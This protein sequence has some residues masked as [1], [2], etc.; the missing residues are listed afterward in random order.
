MNQRSLHID[1]KEAVKSGSNYV[2]K[3]NVE[4]SLRVATSITVSNLV[5]SDKTYCA[6][7]AWYSAVSRELVINVANHYFSANNRTLS[8][9]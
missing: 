6:L 5:I 4:K 2:F 9:N 7:P 1:F 3:F 8:L